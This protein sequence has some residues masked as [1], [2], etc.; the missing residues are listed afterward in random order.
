[1]IYNYHAHTFRC[2][3][4]SGIERNY[5]E[6]AI[7][8][9]IKKMGFSEHAP[10][11]HED[12][13]QVGYRIFVEE[14]KDYFDTLK[15]LREEYKD[16]IEIYIGFE[17]E[18]YTPY[19][20]KMFKFA[21][22]A[23]AEYFILGQHQIDTD[24]NDMYDGLKYVNIFE[25]SDSEE[26]L[27]N[28]VTRCINAVKTGYIS[29]V[30]HPDACKFSGNVDAYKREYSRLVK[31]CK[32]LNVP[33]EINCLGI[34]DNRHY[35]RKELWELVG[36]IGAPVVIGM[37]AHDEKAAYDKESIIIAKQLIK[38]YNLNFIEDFTP[39]FINKI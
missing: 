12:G 25:E 33:L 19:F 2:K 37:D 3:H 4:A 38:D 16:K 34:R 21:I 13:K 9:G 10:F 30:A 36:E 23:G 8:G 15:N 24:R 31:V 29:Y 20:D 32:E 28:Y 14:V 5:I 11:R 1:M 22:D 26:R 18:Y 6:N 39:K 27:S 17:I 35:P 7:K